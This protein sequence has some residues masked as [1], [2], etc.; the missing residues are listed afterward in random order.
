[1]SQMDQ[2]A[3]QPGPMNMHMNN[4]GGMVGGAP[5]M[6]H[7]GAPRGAQQAVF[8]GGD[9]RNLL[10]TYIYD[11]FCKNNMFECANALLKTQD[12]EVQLD[13]NYRPSPSRRP[14]KHEGD[15]GMN[16]IDDDS[17][18]GNDG[19][20]HGEDGDDAKSTKDLPP[21][22]VPTTISGSFLLEWWCCFMDIYWARSK[23]PASV[24]ATA[25]VNQTQAQ[26]RFRN[27]QL[28]RMGP[29]QQAMMGGGM[30]Q[31]YP[32][33]RM[34]AAGMNG[35]VHGG[36]DGTASPGDMAHKQGQQLQRTVLQ[37]LT[38]A[39]NQMN[40]LGRPQMM[41]HMQN[42]E[43]E[44]NDMNGQQRP[45][46][47]SA[48]AASPGNKRVRLENGQYEQVGNGRG[49]TPQGVPPGGAQTSAATQAQQ[50]L[51]ANG[52]NPNQLTPQ[53]FAAFQGQAPLSQQRSIHLYAQSMAAATGKNIAQLQGGPKGMPHNP[54]QAG[55]PMMPQTSEGGVG[56]G[57]GE[58][59]AGQAQG[60]RT[61]LGAS[62]NHALQDYQMQ[63]ML[64][65]QQNKKRLMQAR[66]EQD[67][68][69]SHGDANRPGY[70]QS[71]SP[72]SRAQPSPGPG[73]KP[74]MAGTPKM[75]N[76]GVGPG[77]PL[78]DGHM[79]AH[80]QQRN[81]PAS[82]VGF[83]SQ[84]SEGHNMINAYP[85]GNN[86]AGM[87][88]GGGM[89]RPPGFDGQMA[90]PGMAGQM[91]PNMRAQQAG[92]GQP[93]MWNPQ[94]QQMALQ[95][96]Q[97]QQ[98]QAHQQQSGQP[99]Q[100]NQ[101]PQQ[102]GTPQPGRQNLPH[103]AMPP[104]QAPPNAA[105]PGRPA[106]A[107]PQVVSNQPPTPT[108]SNKPNPKGKATQP[109]KKG[110]APQTQAPSAVTPTTSEPPTPTT[111]QH[112]NSFGN[113][114]HA[115]PNFTSGGPNQPGNAPAGQPVQQPTPNPAPAA[116]PAVANDAI[117][118]ASAFG[119]VDGLDMGFAGGFDEGNA[120]L[121][122]NF[123][124]DSFL[125]T[126][127]NDNGIAFGGDSLQWTEAEIGAADS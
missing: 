123:D 93:G 78:P 90:Q 86:A 83:S 101:P 120:D 13:P 116:P 115:R 45:Q 26:Q 91:N 41:Q 1:M 92:R 30:L 11:Y 5:G 51:M 85:M 46:S 89:M 58:F 52:I 65:E 8:A 35:V 108:Q 49:G 2:K 63:L 57:M 4:M 126:T 40:A 103:Q 76:Q 71:M 75:P 48:A 87:P 59:Y 20:R 77:S 7:G 9:G 15:G 31:G 3:P 32:A 118:P 96:Q 84:G 24:A 68:I 95:Q 104:P 67:N 16:G 79:G 66:Q 74:A 34:M 80:A 109:A 12:A 27:E 72:N 23:M 39:P 81:S 37:R 25:Y 61:A 17:M 28:M 110:T 54:G 29:G 113:P 122:D 117:Q 38:K 42:R 105:N 56:G 114:N 107:S 88:N 97:Q 50:L 62:G 106:P 127:D 60:M 22:K 98:A 43:G 124:F 99:G 125:N 14:Q 64:L 94:Q 47:P 112:P 44:I 69:A 100:Q 119:S 121:L 18:D 21:A 70:H 73:G 53:Q 6:E 10:N 33:A 19:Q 111:P 82:G 55:S 36:Q 102:V